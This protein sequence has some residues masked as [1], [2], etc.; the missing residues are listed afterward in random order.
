MRRLAGFLVFA[1]LFAALLPGVASAH[2]VQHGTSLDAQRNPGGVVE[3][4]TRVRIFGELSSPARKCRNNSIVR[5]IERGGG[6]VDSDRTG[7]GGSFAFR[8]VVVSQTTRFRVVFAGKILNS[9]HPHSHTCDGSADSVR[10][11]VG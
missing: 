5:L 4:G 10:V 7:P 9:N 1:T 8:R 2:T 3:P 6:Q 11:R